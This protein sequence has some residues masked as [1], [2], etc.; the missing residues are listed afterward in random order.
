M[1]AIAK[2]VPAEYDPLRRE[3]LSR[4]AAMDPFRI[5]LALSTLL[6]SL[7]G[8]FLFAFGV[9]VMPGIRSLDNHDSLQAF[10]GMDRVIQNNQPLFMLV[11]VGSALALFAATVWGLWR[12][13][14]FDSFLLIFAAAIYLLGVQLP[15]AAVNVP[16]NNQLQRLDLA[17]LPAAALRKAREDFEPRWTRW[18]AIRTVFATLATALLI[19]LIFRL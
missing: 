7:V 8:G 5:I 3:T 6:C 12:L 11:W 4:D 15:T 16:L 18:N 14:G 9:V 2:V 10:K 19:V 17:T 13:E 1:G